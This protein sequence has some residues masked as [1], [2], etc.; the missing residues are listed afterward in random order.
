MKRQFLLC[1]LQHFFTE[2]ALFINHMFQTLAAFFIVK[3]YLFIAW[4]AL[5]SLWAV[6]I[7]GPVMLA[8]A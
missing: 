2:F 1:F 4:Q 3:V 7:T 6:P 8:I 5:K